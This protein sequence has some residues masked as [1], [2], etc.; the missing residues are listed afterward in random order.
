MNAAKLGRCFSSDLERMGT[1]NLIG[2]G[3]ASIKDYGLWW[4]D[5]FQGTTRV[6]G[7]TSGLKSKSTIKH[8]N[9]SK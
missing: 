4:A 7:E 6:R 1:E 5:D 8:K 3:P 9:S 2:H